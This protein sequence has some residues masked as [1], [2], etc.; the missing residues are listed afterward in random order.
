MKKGHDRDTKTNIS[1]S[2]Y[3]IIRFVSFETE[4]L[5]VNRDVVH[6]KTKSYQYAHSH[7]GK[8]LTTKTR[9]Y[10]DLIKSRSIYTMGLRLFHLSNRFFHSPRYKPLQ[11]SL[12]S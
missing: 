9:F 4:K 2:V 10:F 12:L 11:A 3:L 8:P 1:L 5:V 6:Y 7:F